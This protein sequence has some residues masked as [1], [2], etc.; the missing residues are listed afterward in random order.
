MAN[1]LI[2]VERE[3]T[4]WVSFKAESH[5]DKV[6][7]Y[8]AMSNPDKKIADCIN[9]TILLKDVYCEMIPMVNEETGEINNTPRIVLID[10]EGRSYQ[11]VSFGVFNALKRIFDVFGTPTYETPLAV[12]VIQISSGKNKM[13]SLA[14]Q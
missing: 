4:S 14:V 2:K 10:K 1:E 8:N 6:K 7:L 3:M 5:E 11:A 13:L 12:K 9:S